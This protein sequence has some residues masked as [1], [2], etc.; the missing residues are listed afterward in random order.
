VVGRLRPIEWYKKALDR[1]CEQ[2]V[3]QTFVWSPRLPCQP[4]LATLNSFDLELLPRL[5]AVLLADFGGQND[6]AFG[7]YGRFLGM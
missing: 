1:T 5:N 2:P 3:N 7:G 6:L 4:I